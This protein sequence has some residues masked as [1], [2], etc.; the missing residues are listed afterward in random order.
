MALI[1]F[2]RSNLSALLLL[3]KDSIL[4]ITDRLILIFFCGYFLYSI[5]NNTIVTIDFFILSQTVAYLITVLIGFS[6]LIKHTQLPSLKWDQLFFKMIVKKSMPYALLIFLMSI[7][8]Y[9]DVVMVERIRGNI[10]VA[11][12][13]HGY[14]FFMAFNMLGYLFAGLLLPI[15]S[16]LIKDDKIVPFDDDYTKMKTLIKLIR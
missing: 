7:Y 4:S 15:F 8:Y 6:F 13:A 5:A 1:L 16:K 10:E 3:K 12:Y 2:I 11:N 14:R 9:S